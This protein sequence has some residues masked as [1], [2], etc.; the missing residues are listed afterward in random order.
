MAKILVADDD[1]DVRELCIFTLRFAGH[2]VFG[3]SNGEEVINHAKQTLPDLI[4]MDVR[5]PKI[6]GYEACKILKADPSTCTI[7]VIFLSV[8]VEDSEIQAGLNAG[9]VD[10]LLKPISPDRL[11]EKIQIQLQKKTVAF[12]IIMEY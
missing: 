4:I 10:Y 1:R 12:K 2:E 3:V 6:N 9:A 11:T 7:P 8:R 5:M